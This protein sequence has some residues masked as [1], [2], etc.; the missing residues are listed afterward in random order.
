MAEKTDTE[1]TPMPELMLPSA[2]AALF[3][4]NPKTVTRWA[5]TG[6]LS[7]VKTLGGHRRYPR[8]EIMQHL[9]ASTETAGTR[10]EAAVAPGV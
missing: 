10:P 8:D 9:R 5:E 1:T 3:R 4:V 2:V 6:R 7:S